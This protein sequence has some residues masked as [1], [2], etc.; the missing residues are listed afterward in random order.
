MNCRARNRDARGDV[1]IDVIPILMVDIGGGSVEL[2]VSGRRA[3]RSFE[4]GDWDIRGTH[5]P[6]FSL[7]PSLRSGPGLAT[8]IP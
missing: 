4:T 8:F 1:P 7:Q 5:Q 6:T 3:V 2:M